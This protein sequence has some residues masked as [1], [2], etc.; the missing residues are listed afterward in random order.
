MTFH[1]RLI[2]LE[3]ERVAKEQSRRG[4]SE[5]PVECT[6]LMYFVQRE[7]G[8]RL[9]DPVP[10]DW[11]GFLSYLRNK[12]S[13]VVCRGRAFKQGM[14]G[15]TRAGL[16]VPTGL[17]T[18][19][20]IQRGFDVSVPQDLDHLLINFGGDR[21]KPRVFLWYGENIAPYKLIFM[22]DVE[23]DP[24]H[25]LGEA[26]VEA[27]TWIMKRPKHQTLSDYLKEIGAG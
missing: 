6:E 8:V 2:E 9:A 1:Y 18:I 23:A 25:E 12:D 16:D 5:L 11:Q 15:K 17:D 4:F 3:S 21:D 19:T 22:A 24:H 7:I 20:E 14:M 26:I 10:K 13:L 27:C